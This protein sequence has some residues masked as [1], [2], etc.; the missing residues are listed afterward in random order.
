[1]ML[2]LRRTLQLQN[3]EWSML[4]VH[5]IKTIKHILLAFVKFQK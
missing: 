3:L 4:L 5:K 1:M 2:P